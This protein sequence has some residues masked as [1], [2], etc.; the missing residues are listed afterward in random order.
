MERAELL[1]IQEVCQMVNL[2]ETT[3]RSMIAAG[4]FPRPRKI[5]TGDKKP[6]L[7]FLRRDVL[8]WISRLPRRGR[9]NSSAEK[10]R[11]AAPSSNPRSRRK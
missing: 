7:R 3:I 1:T 5:P 11:D 8:R 10:V 9:K 2:S 6:P 4:T